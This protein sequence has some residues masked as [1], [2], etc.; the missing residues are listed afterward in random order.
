M[1]TPQAAARKAFA[2]YIV[3]L[4]R[5]F[6]P[7]TARAMFGGFGVYRDGLM[8]A[9]LLDERLYFKV[10]EQNVGAFTAR[11]LGP[12][13]YE[14]ANGKVGSLKYHLAPDE[15]YED[16]QE[17]VHWAREAY[18]CAV[19][20]QGAKSPK[21]VKR[22]GQPMPATQPAAQT[23]TVAHVADLAA[24][25]NLGPKSAEMLAAAGLRSLADLQ[26]AGAVVAYAKVKAVWPQASLNL[27]WA[28]EGALTGRAWQEVAETDRASL[29]MA[30]EDVQH[31]LPPGRPVRS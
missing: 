22:R 7:V 1:A 16:S 15:V 5:P 8:F 9:L 2:A 27:L 30:L 13:T 3:D 17:M 20:A 18:A 11:G 28:L 19:R 29:L 4:M 23:A 6:A 26:A 31:H 25:P 10:D 14:S 12:F 21:G 24:L